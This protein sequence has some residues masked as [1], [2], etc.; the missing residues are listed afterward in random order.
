MLNLIR[1]LFRRPPP[2]PV[3]VGTGQVGVGVGRRGVTLIV[4]CHGATVTVPLPAW[5]ARS[6]AADLLEFAGRAERM[7][8]SN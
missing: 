2:A 6:I 7:V 4:W 3:E 1:R 5:Q 8:M